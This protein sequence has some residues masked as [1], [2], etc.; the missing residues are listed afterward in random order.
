[1][2]KIE[3][4]FKDIDNLPPESLL[5][6]MWVGSDDVMVETGDEILE[7]VKEDAE[8]PNAT[9]GEAL[10]WVLSDMSGNSFEVVIIKNGKFYQ[11]R[12]VW[13]N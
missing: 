3:F 7:R 2:E 12:L 9:L 1:M 10:H 5:V 8:L 13:D 11:V 4:K 6:A